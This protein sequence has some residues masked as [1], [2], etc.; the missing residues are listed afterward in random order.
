MSLIKK[1]SQLEINPAM[2][3]LI[4]GQPGSGKTTLACSAPNA[5]LFDFDGGVNRIN[6]AH[7]IPT[8]QV[9]SWE[10][11][12]EALN[13]VKTSTEYESIVVDTVGKMLAYMEDYIKRTDPKKR[14]A[15]GSLSLQGYGVRKQMFINFIK[16]S[17]TCGKHIIFVA[18]E[19]EQKRNEETI[20]RPEVG[21][22]S[23]S[24]LLKELDLVGFLEMNDKY[25]TIS[26]DPQ[27]KFYAKNS[28]DMQGIIQVPALIDEKGNPTGANDFMIKVIANYH[29]RLRKNKELTAKYEALCDDIK[30][31]VGEI[32]NAEDANNLAE[33]IN[34]I[35][36]VYNSKAVAGTVFQQRVRELN[37]SY[38]KATKT[39]SDAV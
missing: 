17:A 3:A 20:I 21:G 38:N 24:D 30:K 9:H 4:Y 32:S 11:A 22:S 7:Q 13:E 6:G 39:Y 16:E 33:W 14:K 19:I 37:L 12:V 8:V 2:S 36:H 35:E 26:F 31:R 27:D 23:A 15:D 18:H 5:V 28:C 1:P 29:N 34:C 10:E 25:R